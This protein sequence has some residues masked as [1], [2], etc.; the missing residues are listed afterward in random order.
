M[1]FER[2][3]PRPM[4]VSKFTRFF[5]YMPEI[6]HAQKRRANRKGICGDS[7]GKQRG[8]RQRLPLTFV[9]DASTC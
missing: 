4:D 7:D 9:A 8:N 6:G 1:V 3:L 5:V 2:N